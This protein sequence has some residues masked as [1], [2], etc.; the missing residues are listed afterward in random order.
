[1]EVPVLFDDK[2]KCCGCRACLNICPVSA[3]SMVEDEYGFEY[4]VIDEDKCIRC[5]RCKTVCAFQKGKAS[6]EPLET[7]AAINKD[8]EI[9][10]KS[11]SGGIFAALA[12]KVLAENG[13]VFGAAFDSEWNVKHI[14]INNKKD[15]VK[16]QGSKYTYCSTEMTY[17]EALEALK[18][19]KKVLYSGTPCQIAGLYGFLGKDYDKLITV[20]LICHGVPGG[21]MFKDYL[22][23]LGDEV[24]AF[25]FRDK[26]LGWGIN[27]RAKV[28]KGGKIKSLKIWQSASPYLYYFTQNMTFRDNCYVCPYACKN[29][30][31]DITIGDYWGIEKAHKEYLGKDGFNVPEGISVVIAN[32]EKAVKVLAEYK[33]RITFKPSDFEKAAAGNAMLR[34]PSKRGN[35]DAIMELYKK[36]GFVAVSARFNKNIGVR[37]Y[38]S[39]IKAMLPTKLKSFLKGRK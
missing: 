6:N 18:A 4:P 20:D 14:G 31:A 13:V 1:M 33:D 22:N 19:D 24:K 5:G 15:L 21:K 30:P 38:S 10:K 28:M 25:T 39:Q 2:S 9:T 32:T 16:L 27:G 11:S 17:K 3:I 34:E 26:K 36:G 29:R 23:T 7:Y 12:D 37:K 35:R 8:R